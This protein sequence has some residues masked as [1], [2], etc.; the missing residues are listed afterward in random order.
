MATKS[1][2]VVTLGL[3]L[4]VACA[5]ALGI[6]L[7]GPDT[8]PPVHSIN[9]PFKKLDYSSLPPT[10]HFTSRTGALLAYRAYP[11]Y[12]GSVKNPVVLIHGSSASSISMH[13]LAQALAHAGHPAYALD[14]RG[15]GDSGPR[16]HI[17]YIGQL[18][19]DLEDFVQSAAMAS[20]ATLVGFSS[21]GGFALRVAGS[22]R[23]DLFASYLLLSPFLHQD[24]P[25]ARP[26]N[27]GWVDIGVPRTITLAILNEMGFTALNHLPI[28]RFAL[29]D[30]ARSFL[31]PQYSFSLA[32][33]FR[34]RHDYGLNIRSA[35]RP[36]EIVAG[37]SDEVFHAERFQ[38]VFT[39]QG[40]VVPVTIIPDANHIELTLMPAAIQAVIAA[41]DRLDQP[42]AP[43]D[44]GPQKTSGLAAQD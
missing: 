29:N 8:P 37:A 39:S 32:Q 21:G 27:G 4:V 7:G 2:A 13:V 35:N 19:D 34:P 31:T 14:I 6:L 42:P 25:T 23:Q 22:A 10:R 40:K 24:A 41:V 20:R 36:M 28:V 1:L 11:A 9:D 17:D 44:A 16:G 18:E 30:E 43:A 12:N 15:H 33:N 26:N 38:E 3:S 5:A